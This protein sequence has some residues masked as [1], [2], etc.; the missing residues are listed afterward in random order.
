MML[1]GVVVI[2]L[3]LGGGGFW[4]VTH[5]AKAAA[6]PP[7]AIAGGG[8]PAAAEGAAP[9]ATMPLDT[10]LVNLAD[11][12]HSSFLKIGITLGLGKAI[13]AGGEQGSPLTPEIRDT[14]LS[15]LTQ[16]QSSDLLTDSGKAKLKTDLL[17]ALQKRLPQLGVEDIYFTSFLI[18]Q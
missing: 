13:K 14:I 2:V 8:R 3:I 16:W 7:G 5:R 10:F 11:P 17:A 18:Q 6:N 1:V 9:V 15:V 12:S 4:F